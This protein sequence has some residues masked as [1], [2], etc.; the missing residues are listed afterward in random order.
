MKSSPACA[1]VADC[2]INLNGSKIKQ[3]RSVFVVCLGSVCSIYSFRVVAMNTVED[4]NAR[5]ARACA[6]AT[7]RSSP[8]I[9]IKIT[10]YFIANMNLVV[11]HLFIYFALGWSISV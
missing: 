5:P 2:H 4:M 1:K 8:L 11:L 3:I 6:R 9:E 10:G 7:L